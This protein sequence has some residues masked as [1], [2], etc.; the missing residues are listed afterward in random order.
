[1]T[2]VYNESSKVWRMDSLIFGLFSKTYQ[3][4][5]SNQR[6]NRLNPDERISDNRGQV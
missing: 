2:A 5:S 3:K 1:M 6:K 4:Y